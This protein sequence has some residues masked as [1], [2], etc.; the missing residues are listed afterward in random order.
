MAF[1]GKIQAN[2]DELS[3]IANQFVQ[4]SG[5]VADLTGKMQSLV[6]DLEG[7]GWIG[8][9]AESFYAEMYD[10]I[11]PG[12]ER[13]AQALED[14]GQATKQISNIVSQAEHEA[15]GVFKF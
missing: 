10:L 3:N 7:G 14:A 4:E 11:F 13:L 6:S 1:G 5:A 15:S 2:Y 9:G 8:R 12:L